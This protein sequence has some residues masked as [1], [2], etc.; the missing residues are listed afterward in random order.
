MR[1]HLNLSSSSEDAEWLRFLPGTGDRV[2]VL[3]EACTLLRHRCQEVIWALRAT[4]SC[5][6]SA[7]LQILYCCAY[8]SALECFR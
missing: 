3:M 6:F 4:L 1:Q 8:T 5:S 7:A 2:S